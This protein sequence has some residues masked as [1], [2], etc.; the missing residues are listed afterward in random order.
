MS[1]ALLNLGRGVMVASN[2]VYSV[3]AFIAD[4]NDTHIYNPT[5][6]GKSS[7]TALLIHLF[8]LNPLTFRGC[9]LGE[10]LGTKVITGH[11]RFHNGQT[12]TL[13]VLLT[14]VSCFFIFRPCKSVAARIESLRIAAVIGSLYC[15]A[16]LSAIKYPGTTWNDPPQ[17][18][19]QLQLYL[20][21]AI[22]VFQWIGYGL[23][24]SGV[25]DV[26][27]KSKRV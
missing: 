21:S 19:T 23:A 20:F 6:P 22:V 12:M 1:S 2:L 26:K 15:V 4:W 27:S 17:A 16:G 25:G 7:Q 18:P 9:V 14:T 8:F 13:G 5:W 3:G 10:T 11:A 24:S